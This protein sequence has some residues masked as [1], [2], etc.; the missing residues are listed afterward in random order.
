MSNVPA[1]E[2]GPTYRPLTALASAKDLIARIYRLGRIAGGATRD[3]LRECALG[4]NER[5][6]A[7]LENPSRLHDRDVMKI[8]ARRLL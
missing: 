6:A 3:E 2:C 5:R 4:V 7:A 1:N 8:A